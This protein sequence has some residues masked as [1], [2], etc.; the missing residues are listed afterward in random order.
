MSFLFCSLCMKKFGDNDDN[1]NAPK[2]LSCGHTFCC[3]CIKEK[4]NQNNEII[5]SVDGEKD[6]RPFEKIPFNK[7]IFDII[8]K[9]REQKNIIY[10]K[11]KE[12]SD[13]TYNIGMIGNAN[14]GKTTLSKCYQDNKPCK[15]ENAPYIPTISLDCFN[16]IINKYGKNIN[17]Q[18]WDTAGQE[19]FNSLTSGYLRGLHGCFIV[20]DVTDRYSFENLKTWIQFY[21][22]FNNSDEKILFILGN[23]IDKKNRTVSFEEGNDFARSQELPYFETSAITMKNINEAF[24]KMINYILETQKEKEEMSFKKSLKKSM[25]KKKPK[26]PTTKKDRCC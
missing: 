13:L 12:K 5:C 20:F 4:M 18:I 26:K 1:E 2:V 17:I 3:K 7:V 11:P 19:R 8:L 23:K 15:E 25:N 16:R 10:E 22:N 6:E 14:V 24:D 9:E 21:S